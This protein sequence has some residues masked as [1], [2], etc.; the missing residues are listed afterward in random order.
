MISRCPHEIPRDY[1]LKRHVC[2][3]VPSVLEQPTSSSSTVNMWFPNNSRNY[4]DDLA[5]EDLVTSAMIVDGVGI[6]NLIIVDS[7][8]PNQHGL[9]GGTTKGA[10]LQSEVKDGEKVTYTSKVSMNSSYKGLKTMLD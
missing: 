1:P 3:D 10:S 9:A 7:L 2:F 6:P 8:L 5:N 4:D